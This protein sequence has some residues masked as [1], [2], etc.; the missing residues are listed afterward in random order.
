MSTL[1][2]LHLDEGGEGGG[3]RMGGDYFPPSVEQTKP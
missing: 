3:G 1:V 2:N